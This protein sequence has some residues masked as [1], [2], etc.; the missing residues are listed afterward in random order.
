VN[1]LEIKFARI[2]RINDHDVNEYSLWNNGKKIYSA[3]YESCVI[4]YINE[5]FATKTNSKLKKKLYKLGTNKQQIQE[6]IYL[7][8]QALN[9]PLIK[10]KHYNK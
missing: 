8:E 2:P 5:T 4:D 9:K 10:I 6:K 7:I 1:D 3:P